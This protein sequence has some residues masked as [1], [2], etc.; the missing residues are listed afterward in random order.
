M[1]LRLPANFSRCNN[2]VALTIAKGHFS[3]WNSGFVEYRIFGSKTET[4]NPNTKPT[5]DMPRP[6][7]DHPVLHAA[8]HWRDRCLLK[9][10]SVFTDKPLWTL[11][12]IEY[13][14]EYYINK[15]D[16]SKR[17]FLVKLEDQLASTPEPVKQLAAEMLWVMYLFPVPSSLK[18]ETKREHIDQ[19]WKWS[20]EELPDAPFDLGEALEQGIGTTGTAF[21]TLKWKEFAFFIE[22]MKEW[23]QTSN[24]NRKYLLSD[25]WVFAEWMENLN[26]WGK[27][28]LRNILLYLL[29][30]E[31]FEPFAVSSQ[32]ETIVDA[33][34]RYFG[35]PEGFP[36]NNKV[37]LDRKILE[38]R[39][40]LQKENK[41]PSEFD[42]HDEPYLKIWRPEPVNPQLNPQP[43]PPV[44]KSKPSRVWLF[45]QAWKEWERFSKEGIIAI[46]YDIG[47]LKTF[48][49]E[50]AILEGL[51]GLANMS[52]HPIGHAWTCH[53]FTHGIRQGDQVLLA[54][55][56][57][58]LLGYGIV[59]S[60]YIFQQDRPN[61]RHIRR[62][63]WKLLGRWP[64]PLAPKQTRWNPC[65]LF[66]ITDWRST[67]KLFSEIINPNL[68]EDKFLIPEDIEDLFISKEFF[69]EITDSLKRKKNIV[70]QGPPGVGKTFIAKRLA[71]S[72]IGFKAPSRVKMV[73][74]HQSYAYED[75]I[76]GY[77]P[78]EKEGFELRNGVFYSFCQKAAKDPNNRY[79][80]IIDEIN[81]GNL[82]K[83][84]GE[85]MMLIEADKRGSEYA[86]ELTYSSEPFHVP[87]NLYLIGMMN[88]AD[89]S[90]AIV[91]YALRRRFA[92][93]HLSPAFNEKFQEFLVAK[94][95]KETLVKRIIR[96]LSALNETI[97]SDHTNLGPGFEIGH[98]YFCPSNGDETFDKSWYEAIIQQEVKPLL[99]EY[100]FDK[101][102]KV[103]AEVK[104][105]MEK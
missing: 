51:Q 95:V 101:P 104:F 63:K 8:R 5:R 25:P 55:N 84:F 88:T 48:D 42:F 57:L 89:R 60:D 53:Q 52:E 2:K 100:W 47:D 56:G 34:A 59:D 15:P 46:D 66:D 21:G 85:L 90:L 50:D 81:R 62:V 7:E 31:D 24:D 71:Y 75:F 43:K 4:F 23:F 14:I 74:F 87:G 96:L 93:F 16:T 3:G 35:E 67:P 91:D 33:F 92:F 73:Q 38:I 61:H 1:C 29:F 30:P 69:N 19:V 105:L 49:E 37:E 68:P 76:Q 70:L 28:L 77:R 79:V 17:P 83:I 22:L 36:Y 9:Q 13:L 78:R 10:Q 27:R 82:S 94:D 20:G 65:T 54:E 12:N 72:I 80:F 26:K 103:E 45:G 97:R 98:S 41:A 40:R 39:E 64:L 99:Q 86:L 32:K 6:T 44:I 102:K 18:P 58:N 11:E